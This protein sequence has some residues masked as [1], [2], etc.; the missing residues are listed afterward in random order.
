MQLFLHPSLRTLSILPMDLRLRTAGLDGAARESAAPGRGRIRVIKALKEGRA[1]L[2][3]RQVHNF[4]I[5][6]LPEFKIRTT[7]EA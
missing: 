5:K 6:V 1:C 2:R 4:K 7:D 3:V